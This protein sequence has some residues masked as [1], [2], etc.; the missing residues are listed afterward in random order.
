MC[1]CQTGTS[2]PV[3]HANAA[4][5][6]A[7]PFFLTFFKRRLD[8]RSSSSSN[9]GAGRKARIPA[10][11]GQQPRPMLC[12][13]C[14]LLGGARIAGLPGVP[15]GS[16]DGHGDRPQDIWA[17]RR[18]R[19]RER[20]VRLCGLL[21]AGQPL[22]CCCCCECSVALRRTWH[23]S[24]P[25]DLPEKCLSSASLVPDPVI[26]LTLPPASQ[27]LLSL[28]FSVVKKKHRAGACGHS[29]CVRRERG[30]SGGMSG[31]LGGASGGGE[32]EL[33]L[34]KRR[35]LERRKALQRRLL[36]VSSPPLPLTPSRLLQHMSGG[37]CFK[38]TR[39]ALCATFVSCT[40]SSARVLASQRTTKE[41][42]G[43]DLVMLH[44]VVC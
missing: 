1:G 33:Q 19:N 10:H 37:F 3:L 43:L 2:C 22:A 39:N 21:L 30:R 12:M 16:N 36:D 29:T 17:R 13:L 26:R 18:H 28:T 6:C 34:Q 7:P 11:C 42:Y 41:W 27:C 35:I 4:R 9:S 23:R 20:T 5:F 31:G 44:V 32:T 14:M 24:S 25:L 15:A 8:S 40:C 38:A